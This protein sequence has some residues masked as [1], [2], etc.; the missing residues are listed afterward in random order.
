M[1]GLNKTDRELLQQALDE[2]LHLS[3]G[4]DA[5]EIIKALQTRLAQPEPEG[6]RWEEGRT[7]PS[8]TYTAPPKK[9]WGSEAAAE[10]RRLHEVNAELV[11]ALKNIASANPSRWDEEVRDQFQEWAQNRARYAIAKATGE[12]Q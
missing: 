8:V 6:Y 5:V 4:L 7:P 10:L 1:S 9:E 12:Q 2:L 3:D 11:E